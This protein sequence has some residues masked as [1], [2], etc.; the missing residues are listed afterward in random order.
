MIESE[1]SD[2]INRKYIFNNNVAEI[3][4][5]TNELNRINAYGQSNFRFMPK[6]ENLELLVEHAKKLDGLCL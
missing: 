2:Y 5:Y 3:I 1:L 4:I 6:A